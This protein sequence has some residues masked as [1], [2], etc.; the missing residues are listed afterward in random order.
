[1]IKGA[2]PGVKKRVITLR[3]SLFP[4][5]SRSA[6]EEIKLKARGQ[7]RCCMERCPGTLC[8]FLFEALCDCMAVG[9][10]LPVCLCCW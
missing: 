10:G 3:K 4:Q 5:T 8:C 1:M 6:L 7:Q 2:C 9:S